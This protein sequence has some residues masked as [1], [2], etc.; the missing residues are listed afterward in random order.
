M[1]E[2]RVGIEG[3]ACLSCDWQRIRVGRNEKESL[4]VR[5]DSLTLNVKCEIKAA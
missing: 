4:Y 2:R 1:G 3:G 5:V